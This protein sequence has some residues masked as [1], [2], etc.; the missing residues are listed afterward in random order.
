MSF[1]GE[2]QEFCF[3]T[4][5]GAPNKDVQGLSDVNSAN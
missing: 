1:S 4:Q 2:Y 5:S 3:G